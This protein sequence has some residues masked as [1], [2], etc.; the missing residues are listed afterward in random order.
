MNRILRT[1][2]LLVLSAT[3][4]APVASL[5]QLRWFKGNTHAHT[6]N[7]DGDSSPADVAAWYKKNGYDFLFITDHEH[8]TAVDEL[9]AQMGDGGKFLLIRG[10]EVTDRFDGKPYHVNGLGLSRVV[11]PQ[12]GTGVVLNLQKNI[13]A[14][15][16]AG[17]IA[18]VNHPN[19]Y[20]ALNARDLAQVKRAA[21]VEIFSGHPRV[22]MM[23]G[24]GMPSAEEIWDSVLT[25]GTVLYG[26]AVDDSHSLKRLGDRLAATPGHGWICVRAAELTPTAILSALEKGEFY[27][28]S[29]VELAEY[30]ATPSEIRIS[31]KPHRDTKYTTHFIGAGGKVLKISHSNESTYRI[32][33]R[34]LYVRAKVFSSNGDFAWTQPVFPKRR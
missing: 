16:E 20:W 6:T 34:E 19:F 27:S 26:V 21:L 7:S 2:A 17:G 10:Q 13:D 15:R 3:L 24:G 33:G 25:T 23:G 4:L 14:V 1:S 11:M 12:R 9:N 32:T 28:S 30:S 31:I 18:Q 5:G 22:N 8:V 29:G